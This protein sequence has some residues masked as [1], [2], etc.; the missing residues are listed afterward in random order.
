MKG[1]TEYSIGL[2]PSANFWA[3]CLQIAYWSLFRPFTLHHYV[4]LVSP[5]RELGVEI[6]NWR[7]TREVASARPV[8]RLLRTALFSSVL[9]SVLIVGCAGI[10]ASALGMS[11]DWERC[12]LTLALSVAGIWFVGF[13][14]G[15]TTE[16][17]YGVVSCVTFSLHLSTLFA[18]GAGI[19]F[20]P[21]MPIGSIISIGA[22]TS[23]AVGAALG[24]LAM[25]I[26]ARSDEESFGR[27]LG[28]WSGILLGISIALLLGMSQVFSV[29]SSLA[30]GISIALGWSVG[31][32]RLLLYFPECIWQ[33]LV[34]GLWR[35]DIWTVL[36]AHRCS[37]LN[38]DET[39][40]FGF[41]FA[42]EMLYELLLD[43]KNV[44]LG[45]LVSVYD[46]P[47]QREP[48]RKAVAQFVV[49]GLAECQ[50]IEQIADIDREVAWTVEEIAALGQDIADITHELLSISHDLN[51]ALKSDSLA[52][53][54][55]GLEGVAG[56]LMGIRDH[57]ATYGFSASE[58]WGVVIGKWYSLVIDELS[59]YP[60][61]Y[62]IANPYVAGNPVGPKR[63]T[64]FRG[65]SD[66]IEA[67][68]Q[69]LSE[70]DRPTIV[71]YGPRRMGKTS[72]L[73]QLPRFLPGHTLPVFVDL[74]HPKKTDS[75]MDFLFTAAH[76][77]VNDARNH[78]R[79]TLPVPTKEDFERKPFV[80]FSDWLDGAALP[81]LETRG[82]T[83]LL[84]FDEFEKL[85][86]AVEEGRVDE[87]VLD[88]LRYTIQH[89]RA[90]SLLFSGMQTFEEL[91]P[92]WTSYFISTRLL[93][94]TYLRPEEATD[95]IRHPDPESGFNLEYADEAVADIL[96][97][98][99]CHPYLVQ[100]V[101]EAVVKLANERHTLI[102]TP[103]LA[104]DAHIEALATGEP[105]YRNIWTESTGVDVDTVAA[106][107]TI[108][109]QVAA[110]PGPLA[111][112]ADNPVTARALERLLRHGV[113]ERVGDG[114]QFQVPLV[115]RWVRECADRA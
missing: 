3:L 52:L 49:T 81:A 100:L 32:M 30:L 77:I 95:L 37:P 67:V 88:E 99:R 21:T 102:A 29:R 53:R 111:V 19:G 114:V 17:T 90:V 47:G 69:C 40:W 96:A 74:Q 50:S 55:R 112:A 39:A 46:I 57:V 58:R 106:G 73:L 93:R 16:V 71:L 24:P 75:T 28:T 10:L 36:R 9:W 85:G 54:V 34:Y 25:L 44:N 35:L 45:R 78:S 18:V 110:A 68:T 4:G 113:L 80:A 94:I 109:R 83:L 98:T 5:D 48:M 107:R 62:G 7:R 42:N 115:Q 84:S 14:I 38:W 72:F 31:Y 108:L 13:V 76:T 51:S 87:R 43:Q 22:G 101:C 1:S 41:P 66:L 59:K 91:G 79:L 60:E 6:S 70:Y 61:V 97:A 15:I 89:R 103:G 26:V 65:R 56:R 92:H 64:L 27:K 8:S 104:L 12:W 2:R 11:F 82:F 33:F 105:Y 23:L 20:G 63:A 86:W